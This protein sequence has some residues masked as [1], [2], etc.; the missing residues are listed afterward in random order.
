MV[1]RLV[2]VKY[3]IAAEKRYAGQNRLKNNKQTTTSV[4]I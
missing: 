4:V 1:D 3:P 2:L